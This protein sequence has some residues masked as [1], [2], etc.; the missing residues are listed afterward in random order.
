MVSIV[1]FAASFPIASLAASSSA[2]AAF[3]YFSFEPRS[4]HSCS[5]G[6]SQHSSSSSSSLPSIR[7][8][9]SA[10]DM[11]VPTVRVLFGRAARAAAA[12]GDARLA[13]DLIVS[14]P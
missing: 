9:G 11:P 8:S 2:A 7:L 13:L 3:W 4:E 10:G 5:R 14:R 1:S 12:A 6:A